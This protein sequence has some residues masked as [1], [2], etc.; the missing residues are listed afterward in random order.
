MGHHA[1][2]S[3]AGVLGIKMIHSCAR[4]CRFHLGSLAYGS[5]LMVL[6]TVPNVLLEYISQHAKSAPENVVAKATLRAGQCCFWLLEEF[7]QYVTRYAYAYVAVESEPF[8]SAS[9]KTMQ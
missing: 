1:G 4:V 6:V 7:L 8:C 3:L 5:L 9:K 2:C